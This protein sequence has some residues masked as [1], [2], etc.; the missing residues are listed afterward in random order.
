ML[1]IPEEPEFIQTSAEK[2]KN[3]DYF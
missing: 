2:I 3:D 1:V